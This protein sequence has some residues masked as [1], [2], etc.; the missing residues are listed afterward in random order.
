M[1]V[2][3]LEYLIGKEL[4]YYCVIIIMFIFIS[5]NFTKKKKVHL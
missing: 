1:K 2:A 3:F 5:F 4:L